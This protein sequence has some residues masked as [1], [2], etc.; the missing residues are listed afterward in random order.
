MLKRIFCAVLCAIMLLSGVAAYAEEPEETDGMEVAEQAEKEETKTIY[1]DYQYAQ[2]TTKKGSLNMRKSAKDKSGLV[3]AIPNKTM[4][5]VLEVGE[6]WTEVLYKDKTGFVKNS[7][8]TLLDFGSIKEMEKG[9]KSVDVDAFKKALK[10]LGYYNKKYQSG[11]TFDDAT[12]DAVERFQEY[13]SLPVT[14]IVDS[15]LYAFVMWGGAPEYGKD[16]AGFD[17]LTGLTCKLSYSISNY[18]KKDNGNVTM[19]VS[20]KA[21]YS[22]GTEPY[23]IKVRVIENGMK[24]ADAP[25]ASGSPFTFEWYKGSTDETFKLLLTVTDADGITVSAVAHVALNIPYT[26]FVDDTAS[27]PGDT[28]DSDSG[29]TDTDTTDLDIY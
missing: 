20:Y 3:V 8:I 29:D 9:T 16:D 17:P 25:L 13:N 6:E 23:K 27:D 19:S 15:H 10:K 14:G 21:T 12:V 4:I 11:K 26:M 2:V 7:F 1:S 5:R 24:E 22:G 18:Q 28:Q